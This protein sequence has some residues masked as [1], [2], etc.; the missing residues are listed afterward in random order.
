M[1]SRQSLEMYTAFW[2]T[3]E[4]VKKTLKKT[5]IYEHFHVPLNSN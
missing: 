1:R 2:Q 5:K 3:V 4:N